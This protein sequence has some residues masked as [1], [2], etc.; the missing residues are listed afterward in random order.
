VGGRLV[1]LGAALAGAAMLAPGAAPA[2]AKDSPAARKQM[3]RIVTEWSTRLN[4]SDNAGLARL[5]HVPAIIVQGQYEYRL[6]TLKQVALFYSL[7]PCAGK[8]VAITY[9]GRYA[10]VVFRLSNRGKTR[11]DGPGQLAAARFEIV[12][13]KITYWEQVPVPA[14][15]ARIA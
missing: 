13:G 2:S 6:R 15:A 1:V 3:A 4:A 10:T 8:V 5:Y 12:N 9:D 14:S 7:L 11:C